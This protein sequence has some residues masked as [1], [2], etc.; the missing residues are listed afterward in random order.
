[1][2]KQDIIDNVKTEC[3]EGWA[4]VNIDDEITLKKKS[5]QTSVYFSK[6]VYKNKLL[7]IDIIFSKIDNNNDAQMYFKYSEIEGVEKF[8]IPKKII[9]EVIE[10]ISKTCHKDFNYIMKSL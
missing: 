5:S 1:M 8:L 2:T 6:I 7:G 10:K 4:S 3:V 9:D